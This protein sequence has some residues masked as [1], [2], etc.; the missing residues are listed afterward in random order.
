MTTETEKVTINVNKEAIL[1][2]REEA[3]QQGMETSALIQRAIYKLAL[4]TGRMTASSAELLRAQ[5]ETIDAFI[6][7]ARKLY[8]EGRF[9]EHFVLTVFKAAMDRPDVRELYERAVGGDAYAVKL[10]GKTPLNMYLGWYTKNAIGAEPKLG[11]DGQPLRLQVR[12]E[13]IQSYTLLRH[14]TVGGTYANDDGEA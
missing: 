2:I 6:S 7:L 11:A 9:D 1:A 14:R 10:P 13:P 4:S 3:Q 8:T 12:G 5:N